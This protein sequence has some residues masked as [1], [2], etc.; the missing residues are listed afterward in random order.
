MRGEVTKEELWPKLKDGTDLKGSGMPR[1][2]AVAKVTGTWDFG[3]DMGLKLP[4]G[5]LH[6]KLVQAEVSH[7]NILAIDT[8]EAEKMPGVYKVI[9]YKDVPGTNRI[10]GLAFPANKGS[11]KE[12]PILND[13]KIFQY[14]DALAM[15]LAYSPK[16]AEEA[17]KKVKVQ[18]EELPAYMNAIDAM[19]EDAIEIHPGTP[20]VYF[21]N[22]NIKG[23]EVEPLFETLPYVVE[24]DI[25]VGRQP[26]LPLEPD[27]GFAYLDEEG[28]LI[29]HS[30]SIGL[31]LHA[32]MVAEGIEHRRRGEVG[33]MGLHVEGPGIIPASLFAMAGEA[34]GVAASVQPSARIEGLAIG[35]RIGVRGATVL[36]G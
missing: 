33:G 32:L 22:H 13:K 9:T 18:I 26:H 34:T 5:T 24:D 11:G 8:A 20:N 7:A 3:A 21:E 23:E 28:K 14:G 19:D 1:P 15:V 31:Q 27:V 17:A 12:R 36:I 29:I 30:K 35:K 25:Y 6:I 2:S 16:L 4:D 10:N